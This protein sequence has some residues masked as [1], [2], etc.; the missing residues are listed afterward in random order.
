[1]TVLDQFKKVGCFELGRASFLFLTWWLSPMHP[2]TP[3]QRITHVTYVL[4]TRTFLN[5]RCDG[6]TTH[7]LK[8]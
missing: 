8:C 7:L 4:R 2:S 5:A 6:K 3:R 1:M